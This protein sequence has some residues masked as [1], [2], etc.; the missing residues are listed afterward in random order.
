[1]GS[2]LIA[3]G[4][5]AWIRQ[6]LIGKNKKLDAM[7]EVDVSQDQEAWEELEKYARL[8]GISIEE[9]LENRRNFRFVH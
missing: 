1:M 6:I 5:F 9:A 8:E 4:M 3:I 2:L 7:A